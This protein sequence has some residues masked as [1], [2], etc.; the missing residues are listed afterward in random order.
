MKYLRLFKLYK[1]D[2]KIHAVDGDVLMSV[3]VKITLPNGKEVNYHRA[4]NI[5]LENAYVRKNDGS[6]F[7]EFLTEYV[8]EDCYRN[9]KQEEA[10]EYYMSLPKIKQKL[11]Q[12]Y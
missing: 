1:C 2:V 11:L 7:Q 5:E 4:M 6:T 12:Y 3:K 9:I 10:R 8:L